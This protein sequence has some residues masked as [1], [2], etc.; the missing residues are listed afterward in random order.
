MC[1]NLKTRLIHWDSN[2]LWHILFGTTWNYWSRETIFWLNVNFYRGH[3]SQT[4]KTEK[5]EGQI[6]NKVHTH[7]NFLSKSGIPG[8]TQRQT[9]PMTERKTDHAPGIFF[10]LFRGLSK[11]PFPSC[12]SPFFKARL[13][14][15]PWYGN[16]FLF[17]CSFL[18][19]R[20]CIGLA[21]FE[22][23]NGWNSKYSLFSFNFIFFAYTLPCEP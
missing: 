21:C 20:F 13:S 18:Q 12:P 9:W 6:G 7:K 23:E 19:E 15:R 17:S 22:S 1:S 5:L 11:R 10:S 8:Y 3:W 4:K 14:A 16:Y 2:R